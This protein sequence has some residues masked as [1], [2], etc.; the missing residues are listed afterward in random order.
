MF[1]LI[2]IF[3]LI[4]EK[5]NFKK[6]LFVLYQIYMPKVH[7][8]NE[9]ENILFPYA[10]RIALWHD[11]YNV[12]YECSSHFLEEW[13]GI[14][15]I[16]LVLWFRVNPLKFLGISIFVGKDNPCLWAIGFSI[17]K[18]M[19]FLFKKWPSTFLWLRRILFSNV[20]IMPLN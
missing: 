19:N 10:N 9:W 11:I 12:A 4:Q 15:I 1:E 8:V 18:F 7:N 2:L 14:N 6:M 16:L 5:K 20:T 17:W 13:N 3:W